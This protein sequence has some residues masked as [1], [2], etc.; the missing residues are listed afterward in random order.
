MA[1]NT[2]TAT[3]SGSPSNMVSPYR[4][5]SAPDAASAVPDAATQAVRR[6][7]RRATVHRAG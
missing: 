5:S 2:V 4:N 3:Y 6:G 1:A 7:R